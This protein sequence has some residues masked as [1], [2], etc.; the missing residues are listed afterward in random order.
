MPRGKSGKA[1]GSR[2]VAENDAAGFCNGAGGRRESGVD[3]VDP[4][5]G[6]FGSDF[7]EFRTERGEAGQR[8]WNVNGADAL[9]AKPSGAGLQIGEA[10]CAGGLGPFLKEGEGIRLSGEPVRLG[11][12]F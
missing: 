1:V 10:F 4:S 2:L 12:I 5:A 3:L 9:A 11:D 6:I 8:G 7:T